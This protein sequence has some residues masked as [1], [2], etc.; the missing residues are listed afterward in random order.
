MS[1]WVI[2]TNTLSVPK[3][4]SRIGEFE[5]RARAAIYRLREVPLLLCPSSV[6][7]V[8]VNN[9]RGKNNHAKSW[10]EKHAFYPQGFTP[11][12]SRG[13]LFRR[14]RQTSWRRDYAY[15]SHIRA[16]LLYEL[17]TRFAPYWWCLPGGDITEDL[18]Q[19][20][21]T[22]CWQ[23]LKNERILPP[24]HSLAPFKSPVYLPVDL[25]RLGHRSACFGLQLIYFHLNWF[26]WYIV[27]TA[28]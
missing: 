1:W 8:T 11:F 3:A 12:F 28:L 15:S 21:L 18:W 6:T 2:K 13:F 27:N 25:L 14:G 23:N 20:Q 7:S 16:I 17:A 9:L 26:A 10:G 22:S 5:G 24:P 19:S 4:N